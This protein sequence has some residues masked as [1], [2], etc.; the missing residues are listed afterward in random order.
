MSTSQ[1][2]KELN[3]KV[4]FTFIQ[5]KLCKQSAIYV[6]VATKGNKRGIITLLLVGDKIPQR[7]K[8]CHKVTVF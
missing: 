7:N 5:I 2:L 1:T 3:F 6:S 4:N 8:D